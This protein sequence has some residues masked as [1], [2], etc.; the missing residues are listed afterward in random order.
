[1][2]KNLFI[3]LFGS[4]LYAQNYQPLVNPNH[5]WKYALQSSSYC[6]PNESILPVNYQLRLGNEITI[7]Q[8]TYREIYKQFQFA[9]EQTFQQIK[10]CD[11]TQ[12]DSKYLSFLNETNFNNEVLAGYIREDVSNKKIY[13]LP[14]NQDEKI[15]YT[16]QDDF[17]V[18][19]NQLTLLQ[20]NALTAYNIN[21]KEYKFALPYNSDYYFVLEQIGDESDLINSTKTNIDGT[22][23]QLLAFSTDNGTTFYQRGNEVLKVNDI[24]T[25]TTYK[26]VQNP[27]KNNLILADYNNINQLQIVDALGKVILTRKDKFNSISTKHLNKGTYYLIIHSKNKITKIQ[28]IIK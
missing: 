10:N 6:S 5:V 3:F 24:A 11:Q 9:D 28:F 22:M 21:T 20:T 8:N 12:E 25:E 7:N 16:F 15:L 14:L 19:P 1:M 27:V 23:I 26:I 18:N 4:L 2:K 17:T 13:V